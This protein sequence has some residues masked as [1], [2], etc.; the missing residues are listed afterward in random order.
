MQQCG[1]STPNYIRSKLQ[2][3]GD[4]SSTQQAAQKLLEDLIWARSHILK[5]WNGTNSKTAKQV[6][7]FL[8]FSFSWWWN[9]G[10]TLRALLELGACPRRTW[11]QF[12]SLGYAAACSYMSQEPF[13]DV[14]N[15]HIRKSEILS[16]WLRALIVLLD[17]GANP[18]ELIDIRYDEWNPSG[19]SQD[20]PMTLSKVLEDVCNV[21]HMSKHDLRSARVVLSRIGRP[22]KPGAKDHFSKGFED[23]VE[24]LIID[25]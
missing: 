4:E 21:S 19:P 14:H 9:D 24:S 23:E 3:M 8:S 22:R 2:A 11:S 1:D 25:L 7:S 17:L 15:L 13:P 10:S 12:V 16:G 18:M 20:R 6:D 5:C